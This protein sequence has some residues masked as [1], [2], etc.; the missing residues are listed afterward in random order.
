MIDRICEI[1]LRNDEHDYYAIYDVNNLLP[2]KSSPIDGGVEIF[3]QLV[4]ENC[5]NIG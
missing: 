1:P 3:N 5:Y 2:P 4:E